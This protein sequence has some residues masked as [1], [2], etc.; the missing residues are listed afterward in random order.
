MNT[1]FFGRALTALAL[2]TVLLPAAY[3]QS[4]QKPNPLQQLE[5]RLATLES[6]YERERE[7]AH[8][9]F[10]VTQATIERAIQNLEQEFAATRE[11][12]TMELARTEQRL[13]AQ[14][15]QL[16]D[17]YAR[18]L[19][20]AERA[21]R[22]T[23]LE[24][25]EAAESGKD[26]R[27]SE[28]ERLAMA[29]EKLAQ[30]DVPKKAELR[31]LAEDFE[32]AKLQYELTQRDAE[33]AMQQGVESH[34]MQLRAAAVEMDRML[35]DLEASYADQRAAAE[36]QL[37]RAAAGLAPTHPELGLGSTTANNQPSRRAP[38]ARPPAE[39]KTGGG[40]ATATATEAD[41]TLLIELRQSVH[42][43][44]EEV[45]ALRGLVRDIDRVVRGSR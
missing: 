35:A 16:E 10:Q 8:R 23:E 19:A 28:L 26:P 40:A 29:R 37:R 4:K 31:T 5:Q 22:T 7:L 18:E 32:A 44:R 17:R 41:R 15:A 42:E 9:E 13:D 1:T 3:G 38:A 6:R 25:A 11:R 45:R 27:P 21:L 30:T 2:A 33:R 43:L 24:I 12:S 14:R 36:L 34:Q 20:L 39:P